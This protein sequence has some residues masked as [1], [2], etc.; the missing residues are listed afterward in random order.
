MIVDFRVR[1]PFKSFCDLNIYGLRDPNPDPV[2]APAFGLT[3]PRIDPSKTG[4][5]SGSLKKLDEAGIDVAVAM[6]APRPNRMGR[7]ST[8]TSPSWSMRTRGDSSGSVRSMVHPST[9]SARLTSVR[10]LVQGRRY[11]QPMVQPLPV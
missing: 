5:S 6:G 8:P 4:P 10:N 11:G 7:F 2:T 1:P 9:P 3:C